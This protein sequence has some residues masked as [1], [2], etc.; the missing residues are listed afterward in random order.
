MN[1]LEKAIINQDL[2][3]VKTILIKEPNKIEEVSEEGIWLP[4][5]AART[6]NKKIVQYIVEYS[7]ASFDKKDEKN[8]GILHYAVESGELSIV[9]YFVERE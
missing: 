9:K 5:L 8:R 1:D 6:G 2:E 7:R 4:F 3:Q